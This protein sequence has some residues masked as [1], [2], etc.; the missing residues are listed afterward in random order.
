LGSQRQVWLIP[1]V[2]ETQGVPVK[3]CYPLTTRA[4][5]ERLRDDS[6]GGAIQ[7]NYLYFLPF[8]IGVPRICWLGALGWPQFVN[9]GGQI[10]LTPCTDTQFQGEP[11][12]WG[13]WIHGVGKIGNFQWKSLFISETMRDRPMVTMER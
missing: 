7:I 5:P 12:Q 3:L 8:N 13:R 2:D 11:L 10:L 9:Y 6:C 1:L 4:I